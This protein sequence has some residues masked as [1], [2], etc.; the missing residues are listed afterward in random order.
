MGGQCVDVVGNGNSRTFVRFGFGQFEQFRGA[1]QAIIQGANPVDDAVERRT[2]LA[3][4]L[5]PFRLVPDVRI[6]QLA[7]YFLEPFAPG[8]V[9]K[10]TP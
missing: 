1:G 2:L 6:F 3:E 10:D 7:G 8:I 9:V 5:R 4:L